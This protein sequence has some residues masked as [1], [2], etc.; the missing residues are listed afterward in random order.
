MRGNSSRLVVA[1]FPDISDFSSLAARRKVG[2]LEGILSGVLNLLMFAAKMVMALAIQS[3]A[4]LADAFHTLADSVTSFGLIFVFKVSSKPGDEE[5]PYGHGRAEYIGTLILSMLVVVGG[6]EFIRSSLGR[7]QSPG[8]VNASPLMFGILL[9]TAGVKELMAR[10]SRSLGRLIDS[11]VLVADA[12][13]HRSD[14]FSSLAPL[15]SMA[16]ANRGWVVWDGV[17]GMGVG[18]FIVWVGFSLGRDAIWTLLGVAPGPEVVERI[19]RTA[20]GIDGVVDVHHIVV[21][22]YG[23]TRYISL[24]MEV[25]QGASQIRAHDMASSVTRAITKDLHAHVT[26]HVDPVT[27]S[28]LEA[29]KVKQVLTDLMELYPDVRSFHDLRVVMA[30]H[31][32]L[33][34]VKLALGRHLPEGDRKGLQSAFSRS[35]GE[36]FPEFEN[37]V[38]IISPVHSF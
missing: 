22:S 21:H 18:F 3:I 1:L 31:H 26:V 14:V 36:R 20:R 2:L 33:I 11:D 4:L 28:G 25:D 16:L 10:F 32:K 12:W 29:Q 23:A 24:H 38:G 34:L 6:A 17:L 30:R 13:H 9:V 8:I 5:H 37:E 27:T 7:I 35:L 15:A 19:R